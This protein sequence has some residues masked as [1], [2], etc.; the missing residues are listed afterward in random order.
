[1]TKENK[2]NIYKSKINKYLANIMITLVI[3]TSD[4]FADQYSEKM[5][6]HY[7]IIEYNIFNN[8]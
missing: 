5:W 1:M 6:H 7:L 3:D 4:Q 2:K 8:C